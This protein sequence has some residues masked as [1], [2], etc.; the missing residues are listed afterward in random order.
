MQDLRPARPLRG[1]H[2]RLGVDTEPST[3]PSSG[4]RAREG[5]GLPGGAPG[6]SSKAAVGGNLLQGPGQEALLGR[7]RSSGSHQAFRWTQRSASCCHA[8]RGGRRSGFHPGPSAWRAL[9]SGASRAEALPEA[10]LCRVLIFQA[11]LVGSGLSG[12]S[13]CGGAIVTRAL[14]TD[15]HPGLGS[16]TEV[17]THTCMSL[18]TLRPAWA[19]LS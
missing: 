8:R 7:E 15:T 10:P 18:G 16:G 12:T 2:S 5:P 14:D 11:L 9:S 13:A 4:G 19:P 17:H 3:G 1:R 6:S